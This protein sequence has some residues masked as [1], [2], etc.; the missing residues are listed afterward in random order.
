MF[1]TFSVISKN[2]PASLTSFSKGT[3]TDKAIPRDGDKPIK[4]I[5]MNVKIFLIYLL[6]LLPAMHTEVYEYA[7]Y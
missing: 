5:L 2:I 1:S 3:D 6:L 7:T 4:K